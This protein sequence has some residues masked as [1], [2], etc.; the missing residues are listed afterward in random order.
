MRGDALRALGELEQAAVDYRTAALSR[1][2]HAPSWS[3][4]ALTCLDL[5]EFD[6]AHRACARAIR[7]DPRDPEGWWVR[8]LLLEWKGDQTGARRALL[9]ARFLDPVGFPLP[10]R[11]DDDQVERIIEQALAA[12][13]PAIRE[14]LA[15]VAIIL[16]DQ[17]SEQVLRSY[18][19]PMSPLEILG[20]FSGHSLMERSSGDPWTGLPPTIVLFR[21]N[22]ER[23]ARDEE[24]LAEE[25]RITV[26]HEVG[27][28]LGLDEQDLADRGLD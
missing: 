15:N 24:E 26:F 5:L 18:D 3:A 13:H 10:P 2:D 11:L 6:E 8:S 19:P 12:L 4:L 27:H 14:Y 17:P 28:F 16:E 20:Y 21:R 23:R 1:P 9:H 22:L 25:L 7:E